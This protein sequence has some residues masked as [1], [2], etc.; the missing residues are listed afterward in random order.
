M[1]VPRLILFREEHSRRT[2]PARVDAVSAPGT[3]PPGVYRRGGPVA[4]ITGRAVFAFDA[5]RARFLLESVNPGETAAGVRAATGFDY[6]EPAEA[7][8]SPLLDPADRERLR[9]AVADDL[10]PAYPRFAGALR[11]AT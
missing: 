8:V 5:G 6:D 11:A 7:P 3:S 10:D 1:L 9:G 2:L 4:L